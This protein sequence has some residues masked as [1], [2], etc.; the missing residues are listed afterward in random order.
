ML[1]VGR[2]ALG[3]GRWALGVVVRLATGLPS[4]SPHSP[5]P[6]PLL[7]GSELARTA[8]FGLEKNAVEVGEAVE[9]AAEADLRDARVGILHQVLGLLDA[10][11]LDIA[12]EGDARLF[13]KQEA[14]RDKARPLRV[15]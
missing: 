4:F 7:F 15:P 14:G 5:R 9:A 8:P 11:G 6:L 3:V 10:P 12:G 1:G 2:W 13:V